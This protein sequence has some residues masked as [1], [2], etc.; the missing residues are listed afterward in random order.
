[1]LERNVF[2][3]LIVN[4]WHLPRM[5]KLKNIK[6]ILALIL[7]GSENVG[8][9]LNRLKWP[10]DIV[11]PVCFMQQALSFDPGQAVDVLKA[12]DRRLIKSK[13][14]ELNSEEH[15]QN[16]LGMNELRQDLND[17]C[18][19]I[20]NPPR[21]RLI[22][23]LAYYEPVVPSGESLMAKGLVG[24]EIGDAQ[25]AAMQEGYTKSLEDFGHPLET[26]DV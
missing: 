14:R 10:N 13:D 15:L 19:S 3:G 23:H 11:E 16:L 2:P 18:A 6:V 25:K 7:E 5:E 24:K 20:H 9:K 12:R 26:S 17:L 1:L 4:Y 21:T 22:R 8:E